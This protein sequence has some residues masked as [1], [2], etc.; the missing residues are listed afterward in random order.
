MFIK[1]TGAR[2]SVGGR[3]VL[4]E[5]DGPERRFPQKAV[6]PNVGG[7]RG[8]NEAGSFGRRFYLMKLPD[9]P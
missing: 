6:A 7:D 9:F 8:R 5:F 1:K 3:Q 4:H 2:G